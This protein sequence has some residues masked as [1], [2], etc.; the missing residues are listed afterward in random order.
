[1]NLTIQLFNANTAFHVPESRHSS[2][3][4]I[5]DMPP[6]Q[7]LLFKLK[8]D[9]DLNETIYNLKVSHLRDKLFRQSYDNA[10]IC[11]SPIASPKSHLP[12]IKRH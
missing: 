7:R 5:E 8:Q 12:Q 4:S 9:V 6:K 11:I 3:R 2:V 1:M 10:M